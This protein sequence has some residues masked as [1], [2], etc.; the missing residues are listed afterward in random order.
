MTSNFYNDLVNFIKLKEG[1]LT[2]NPQDTTHAWDPFIYFAN[3]NASPC[4]TFGQALTNKLNNYATLNGQ[5]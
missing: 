4:N 5:N 1:G 3:T 2:N